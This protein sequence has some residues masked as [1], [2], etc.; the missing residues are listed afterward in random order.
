MVYF[1]LGSL[2]IE[3]NFLKEITAKF[4]FIRLYNSVIN[5]NSNH[6]FHVF[7]VIRTMSSKNLTLFYS[8]FP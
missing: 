5:N 6:E 7:K 4:A 1:A 2:L 3:G 8:Q